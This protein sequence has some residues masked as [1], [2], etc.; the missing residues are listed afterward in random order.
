MIEQKI[1]CGNAI[2]EYINKILHGDCVEKLKTI[3]SESVDLIF[4][5]PPYFM[6]TEAEL[7][8]AN[9][10]KFTDADDEWDKFNSF[11]EYDA[12]CELWLKECKRILKPTGSIW[13]IGSFQNIYRIGY[14]MQNLGF[15]I[16]NDVIWNKTNAVPNFGGTRFCNAH[17]TMLWCSKGKNN[18]FTFNYKTMKHLNDGE[19][20]RSI[21]Q[22]SLCTESE[23]IKNEYGKKTHSTQKPEALLYKVILSSS[24]P[25]DVILDPFF[26]TGTT[27]VVAKALGRNYIGLECKL[28]YIEIAEARLANTI[29]KPN[30]IELLSLEVLPPKVPMKT[31]IETNYLQFG[32]TSPTAL[33]RLHNAKTIRINGAIYIE[34]EI[35]SASG[36]FKAP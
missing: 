17:E 13:V 8:R 16:L 18:K 20:E 4:A 22:I 15:W 23:R 35:R 11:A 27:G 7:L 31:L 9:G 33:S 12:F 1:I 32:Q 25:N 24:K 21:W 14:I 29:S 5:D 28:K 34:S 30:N 10:D 36:L 3:P 26:G 19:Q 2:G 6:Q